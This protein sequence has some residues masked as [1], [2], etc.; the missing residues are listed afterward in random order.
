MKHF[1]IFLIF[2]LSVKGYG[3]DIEKG[4]KNVKQFKVAS[5]IPTTFLSVTGGMSSQQVFYSAWGIQ[6]RQSP[7][8]YNYAGNL[9]VSILGK[10]NIP[11]SFSFINQNSNFNQGF[12]TAFSDI[13]NRRPRFAQPFNRLSLKPTYKGITLHLGTCALNYSPYSVA[14]HRFEGAAIEYKSE[15]SPIYGSLMWG[16]LLRATPIDTLRVSANNIPAFK[17]IGMGIKVG[18]K[19]QKDKIELILFSAKDFYTPLANLDGLRINPQSNAVVSIQGAKMLGKKVLLNAEYSTSGIVLDQR[20]VKTPNETFWKTF[21]GLL[22]A[23]T[24]TVYRSAYKL[25]AD[26]QGK[27]FKAGVEY[28]HVDPQYRTFGGYFFNNDLQTLSAK[29]SIQLFQGK[30]MVMANT[31]L[32]QDNLDKQKLQ[33]TKRWVNAIN[34]TYQPSETDNL[35]V[36]FSNFS[37][38]SNLQSN[39]IYLTRVA[40]YVALDTLNYQQ[41]N[42]SANIG[43]SKLLPSSNPK[44][45]IKALNV[46]VV[47]QGNNSLQGSDQQSTYLSNII[48]GYNYANKPKKYNWNASISYSQSELGNVSDVFV[49]PSANYSKTWGELKIQSGLTYSWATTTQQVFDV[50]TSSRNQIINGRIGLAYTIAKKHNI[51]FNAILLKRSEP[52]SD[53]LQRNFSELTATIGYSLQFTAL[54]FKKKK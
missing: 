30:L 25:G 21:G 9:N 42:R 18:Y 33:T 50:V 32:Q 53:R 14:N 5:L 24:N 28:S 51:T 26:Y 36:A 54:E 20:A 8:N 6:N 19:H 17:R 15:K 43:Y 35:M 31:G 12:G 45:I 46:D 52:S 49:G 1:Y 44:E 10:I 3:Q 23:N 16:Q 13:F 11:I 7:Y 2:G 39:F 48:A 4:L 34:A 29:G 47:W 40:P 38:F 41:I 27:I 37:N 22:P